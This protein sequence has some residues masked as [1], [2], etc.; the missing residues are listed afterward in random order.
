VLVLP[1]LW[2]ETTGLVLLEALAEGKVVIASRTGGIPEVVGA[3]GRL[4]APGDVAALR[5]ALDDVTS[6]RVLPGGAPAPPIP[7]AE[8]G[9]MQLVALYESLRPTR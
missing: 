9:A 3:N 5:E 8:E 6:G 1:S 4:V 7:T 2:W